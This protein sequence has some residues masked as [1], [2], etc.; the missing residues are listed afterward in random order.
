MLHGQETIAGLVFVWIAD[1][2]SEARED[3]ARDSSGNEIN[4]VMILYECLVCCK[5]CLESYSSV[6]CLTVQTDVLG[7][8]Y[9][10][11][12]WPLILAAERLPVKCDSA[13]NKGPH[14]ERKATRVSIKFKSARGGNRLNK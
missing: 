2:I 9:L 5:H 3:R 14:A 11:S 7:S 10:R 6:R 1:V 12:D 13:L 4:A 8:T